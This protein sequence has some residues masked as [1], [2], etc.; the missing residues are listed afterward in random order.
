MSDEEI[1]SYFEDQE[2]E[3]WARDCK[4]MDSAER[5]AINYR[6]WLADDSYLQERQS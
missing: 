1:D 6:A 2:A 4:I 5:S 3:A